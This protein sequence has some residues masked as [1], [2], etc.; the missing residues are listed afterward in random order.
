MDTR[1]ER[2][3]IKNSIS[4]WVKPSLRVWNEFTTCEIEITA[5]FDKKNKKI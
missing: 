5:F 3:E 4:D 2:K 1:F